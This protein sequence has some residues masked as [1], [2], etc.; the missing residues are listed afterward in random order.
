MRIAI[1]ARVL[2]RDR[3]EGF[4]WYAYE[5]IRRMVLAHPEHEFILFFDRPFDPRFVFAP[6]VTPIVLYPP[7]RHATLLI[8]WFEWS[9]Q[10]ALKRLKPD[11]FFTPDGFLCLGTDVP[12]VSVMHDLNFEHDSR[13]LTPV[14]RWYYKT[15]FPRFAHK[16]R[17]LVT[18]SEFSRADIIKRYNVSPDTIDMVYNGVNEAYRPIDEDSKTDVR[19]RYT[20]GRPFFLYVGIQVPRKNLARIFAA[21]DA[22]ASSSDEDV[23][24]LVVGDKHH[25]DESIEH[26]YGNMKARDSVIFTGHLEQSE[27]LLVMGSAIALTF[28]SLFEGFG[29]PAVEAMRAG[30]PVITSTA[31]CMPEIVGDAAI[32]CDPTSVAEIAD[33]MKRVATDPELRNELIERGLIRS[34]KFSWQY[35]ADGLWRNIQ[36]LLTDITNSRGTTP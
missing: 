13:Y 34:Q 7:A 11:V 9:V 12:T 25:W 19:A 24:L 22:F 8:I 16:A 35:T 29:V 10:R 23:V 1:N 32:L 18:I 26:A 30:V 6:N 17:K 5:T 20:H 2:L 28:V 31:S 27:L 33:A 3:L 36:E 15:F 14:I 4:G 21:F